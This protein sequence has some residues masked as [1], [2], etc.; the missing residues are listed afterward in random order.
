MKTTAP[1]DKL[2]KEQVEFHATG[3]VCVKKTKRQVSENCFL[4]VIIPLGLNRENYRVVI[5][6]MDWLK[7][8]YLCNLWLDA[9]IFF[10]LWDSNISGNPVQLGC[11][12]VEE[13]P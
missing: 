10:D 5:I 2:L 9:H 12:I 3:C 13:S 1:V 7:P 6:S 4:R 11:I 8:E